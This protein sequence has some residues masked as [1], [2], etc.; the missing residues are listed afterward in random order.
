MNKL[1]KFAA[2]LFCCTMALSCLLPSSASAE[3]TPEWD[4]DKSKTATELD[5]NRQT[6]VTLSLPSAETLINKAEIVF[7]MDHSGYADTADIDT[8]T[9]S[10]L[11]KLN[12]QTE[13]DVSIGVIKFDG[14]GI[15]A[16]KKTSGGASSGLVPLNAANYDTILTA[17]QQDVRTGIGGSNTEQPIRMA[18]SMLAD[19]AADAEKFVVVLSDFQTYVYEGSATVDGTTYDNIPVGSASGTASGSSLEDYTSYADYNSWASLKALYDADHTLAGSDWSTDNMFF[20]YG[21]LN[22]TTDSNYSQKAWIDYDYSGAYDTQPTNKWVMESKD[23][24]TANRAAVMASRA[25]NHITGYQRSMLLTYD[26]MEASINAG[27]HVIAY[28]NNDITG[29]NW[30]K[31]MKNFPNDMLNA[32]GDQGAKI[33]LNGSATISDA[34]DNLSAS[35][36]YLIGSGT[37]TDVIDSNF[38]LVTGA[39]CPFTLTVGGTQLNGVPTGTNEWSFGTKD[40]E[41]G[42][43][44]YAVTYT[45]GSTEQFTWTINVPVK[46]AEQVQLSYQLQILDGTAPGTYPTNESATLDYLDSEGE[47]PGEELFEVPTVTLKADDITVTYDPDGGTLAENESGTRTGAAGDALT[48]PAAPT[49]AGYTFGGWYT[50][51]NGRG[52]A[53][54]DTFPGESTTYYANWLQNVTA[55]VDHNSTTVTSGTTAVKTPSTGDNAGT[56]LYLMIAAASAAG[57]LCIVRRNARKQK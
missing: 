40:T 57:A 15:D 55:V 29:I 6:T 31:I 12:A 9:T 11:D 8:A 25:G 16:V 33:F 4:V 23:E 14:W 38:D 49:K 47:N 46:K 17:I 21:V 35:V 30:D 2:A 53:A 50:E 48:A 54:P 42:L 41:T 3:D 51:K 1:R 19:G 7:V 52:T 28:R 37:V 36:L 32:I 18:N 22:A 20:R 44:P 5:E 39:G 34:F 10:L 45:P 24:Y 26:A 27:Y 43:Y 56:A 13:L